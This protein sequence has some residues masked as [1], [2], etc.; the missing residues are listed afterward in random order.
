MSTGTRLKYILTLN[1]FLTP[2]PLFLLLVLFPRPSYPSLSL[3]SFSTLRLPH[4]SYPCPPL[5]FLTSRTFL[6]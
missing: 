5:S 3:V 4:S 2:I 1:P 6:Y